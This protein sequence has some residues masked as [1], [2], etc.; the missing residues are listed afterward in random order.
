MPNRPSPNSTPEVKAGVYKHYKGQ[1]Y[2]VLMTAFLES[3]LEPHVVYVPL[4]TTADRQA[5]A[6]LRSVDDFM[7]SVTVNG[8]IRPRFRYIGTA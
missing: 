3:N 2:L 6:W 7:S 8:L 5:H 4:Y 1:H